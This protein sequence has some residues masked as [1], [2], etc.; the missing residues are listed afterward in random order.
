M[1]PDCRIVFQHAPGIAHLAQNPFF[2]LED[3]L[4]VVFDGVQDFVRGD[5]FV[6]HPRSAVG[7]DFHQGLLF[8]KPDAA[9]LADLNAVI[10]GKFF[11]SFVEDAWAPA[12]M[13]QEAMPM[14]TLIVSGW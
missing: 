2:L 10:V 5:I 4:P 3:A 6:H 7:D 11:R 13:P 12:A 8:A 14:F 9:G 1:P